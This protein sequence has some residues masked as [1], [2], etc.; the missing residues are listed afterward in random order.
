MA[1]IRCVKFS[2][3][4]EMKFLE[5]QTKGGK[6]KT[7]VEFADYIGVK[8][9]TLSKWWNS[10]GKPEGENVRKLADKF[11]LEV[12]D[13]LGLP[14]PDADL[15]YISSNW[16]RING[17]KRRALREQAERYVAENELKQVRGRRDIPFQSPWHERCQP[18]RSRFVGIW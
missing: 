15:H 13:V 17:E 8:Q 4:L 9:Q 10:D 2:Q 7:V 5:W 18:L 1:I 11:G 3:Y 14:R 16:D 12:Y 6:R